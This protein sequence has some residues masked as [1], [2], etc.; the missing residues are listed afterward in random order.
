MGGYILCQVKKAQR[1]YFIE[2]ISTNIYSIEELCFY[3]YHNLYL[4]D[5]T[6]RNEELLKWLEDE[7]GLRV[8]AAKL[9]SR[10][11]ITYPL[12]EFL[13]PI[14]KEINYLSYEEMR[15][16][17]GELERMDQEGFL[18]Q[19]KKKGD[20]LVENGMYVNAIQ[21]Y[22]EVL[23]EE[24]PSEGFGAGVY[25]NLG[26]AYSYL[27]QWEEA[28]ECFGKAFE[29][30][31]SHTDCRTY[32]I[33]YRQVHGQEAFEKKCEELGVEEELRL[34]IQQEFQSVEEK[35]EGSLLQSKEIDGVL[36]RLTLEYHR[37]TSA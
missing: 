37:S 1:P 5:E 24:E 35:R 14:L 17:N 13:Y 11:R 15:T 19:K 2:N 20:C 36:E 34:G 6:I 27:F 31:D 22:R 26:C 9:R 10:L 18:V 32:L 28:L 33:S 21:I 7:L 4:I 25:H 29:R 12:S 30:R 8:L 23:R 16:L 3:L